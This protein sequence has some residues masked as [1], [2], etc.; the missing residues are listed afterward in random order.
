MKSFSYGVLLV[1]LA[2]Q[3]SVSAR[4]DDASAHAGP[5]GFSISSA[6]NNY[7]IGISG[8]VQA[9]GRFFL[10]APGGSDDEFMLRRARLTFD[11]KFGPR[12][13]FRLRP[14]SSSGDTR[15]LDAYVE[16]KLTG[17]IALRAGKFKPPVGL[18]RLQ[19]VN[20]LRLAE[21]SFVTE[22]VPSRDVGVTLTGKQNML[23]WAVGVFNG[24]TDGRT[25][26]VA[27]DGT[28]E[29][30]ARLFLEPVNHTESG[31]AL[32]GVGVA[33]TYGSRDGETTR[34]LLDTYRSAGQKSIFAYRVGTDATFADGDRTRLSPQLYWY[35]GPFGVMAEWV[36]VSQDVTRRAADRSDTLDHQAW[37]LTGEWFIT[38][39]TS[40]YKDPEVPGA[41]QL[42]ARVSGLTADD[43]AF[44]GGDLSFADPTLA[45][46]RA[47]AAAIGVNWFPLSGMKTSLIYEH[48]EF[49]GGAIAGDRPAE[50]LIL[51]RLQQAF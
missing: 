34:P 31:G 49:D 45:I 42:V 37:E 12:L 25:A 11:G 15:I 35:D 29:L 32:L 30:A 46:R 27:D 13:S 22:L 43:A 5:E 40:G 1:A 18:E 2:A 16:A 28:P 23:T 41:V 21:R 26:D 7:S 4:A 20:D 19:T 3:Y 39:E 14:E 24:V 38:G 33:A 36:R 44:S 9:D 48:T 50:K 51:V 47:R 8:L 10:D 6:D 17:T